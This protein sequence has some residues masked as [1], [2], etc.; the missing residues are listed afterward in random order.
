MNKLN[1]QEIKLLA[2]ND[3]VE[4]L[5]R[6]GYEE[7]L[8]NNGYID[9]LAVGLL[10]GLDDNDNGYESNIKPRDLDTLLKEF[11]IK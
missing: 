5:A 8:A 6:N 2:E 1:N 7:W 4:W 10:D 3:Y 11:D 9:W